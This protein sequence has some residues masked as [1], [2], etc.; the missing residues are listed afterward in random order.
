MRTNVGTTD[1][2]IR[3]SLAV[4]FFVAALLLLDGY[5]VVSLIAAVIAVVLGMT[6]LFGVCP[7]YSLLGINTCSETKLVQ[8]IHRRE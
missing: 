8:V 1:A 7:L 5:A 4:G 3:A 6:A 2:I